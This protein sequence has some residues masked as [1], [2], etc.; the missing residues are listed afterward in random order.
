MRKI[1][2]ILFVLFCTSAIGQQV[3]FESNGIVYGITSEADRATEVEFYGYIEGIS[4]YSGAITIPQT[5]E[6][7]GTTYTVTALGEEAFSS[8]TG[9]SS[10]SLP[11][12][13]RSIGA[14]CFY[15]CS[16][17]SIQLPDSL[18]RI[19]DFAFLYSSVTSLHLPAH[20]E[21]YGEASFW[22]RNLTSITVDEANPHYQSIDNWLYSKDS[23]TLCIVPD[24]VTGVITVPSFVRHIGK[25]AFGFNSNASSVLL[26]EGLISIGDFSFNS[27]SVVNNVV[28]PSTVTHIG[29]CPFS[30]CPQLTN[31]T[32]ADG[33]THYVMDGLM[34]YS[35][36]YDTLV[37]C[38]KSGATVT[39]NPNV[40]V[41]GG[42]ENNRSVR[43]IDI[44]AGVTDILDNC[45]NACSFST[46]ALPTHLNSIGSRAFAE[47]SNLTSVTMPQ[48]LR[49]LGEGAFAWCTKL[50][51]IVIPDS[52]KV[53]PKEAFNSDP[54][55]STIVW[56][57][58]VEEIGYAAFWAM[59][60]RELVLP[61]TLKKLDDYAFAACSNNLS[62]VTIQSQLE[63]MGEGV[64]R[65]ANI[66]HITFTTGLPPTTTGNGPLA[67][68]GSL[69]SIVIPCGT[70][71][72]WQSDSYWGQFADKFVE[73]CNGIDNPNTLTQSS[74]QAI[75]VFPNPT[76]G[77][78]H[79]QPNTD[80]LTQSGNQTISS[81]TLHNAMG[82][83]VMVQNS[84]FKIQNSIDLSPL[85]AGVYYLTIK[86][87]ETTTR[88]KVIKVTK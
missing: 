6:Y 10:L 7:E 40:K 20:F 37:S 48:T 28:I 56:G 18:R 75:T 63:S 8:C 72:S 29:I 44:P 19:G 27:C 54:R 81:L 17:T 5:V 45:F 86:S 57:N 33:N 23:L 53:I 51:S 71:D 3:Y 13:I 70:L 52:L 30:D 77:I 88:H 38:H 2:T 80:A 55:L 47:N 15:N 1:I 43:N 85:P 64:F 79:I 87:N 31:L 39:I 58:A 11:S 83:P 34:L 50:T 67:E 42:F 24:G 59:A 32:I 61:P 22:S 73:D 60:A 62:A 4:A 36:N 66:D 69:D 35:I 84:D 9:L 49:T 21:E 78:L 68:V 76:T 41:L 82:Q 65:H 26:P 25:V 16:L 74:N 46:I 14:Y 12:T